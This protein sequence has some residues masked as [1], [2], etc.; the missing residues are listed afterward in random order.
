M[1]AS[2]LSN[3]QTTLPYDQQG[4]RNVTA[5]FESSLKLTTHWRNILNKDTFL[6]QYD[7]MWEN[8]ALSP[9]C[10]ETLRKL[11]N[12][13]QLY[14]YLIKM[15]VRKPFYYYYSLVR[16]IYSSKQFANSETSSSSFIVLP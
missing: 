11:P 2:A 15:T 13:F 14:R 3:F 10:H 9:V 6:T 16:H 7:I 4:L 1:L 5:G 8:L 12:L